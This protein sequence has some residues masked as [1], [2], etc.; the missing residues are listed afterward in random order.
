MSFYGAKGARFQGRCSACVH[1]NGHLWCL[2]NTMSNRAAI[3]DIKTKIKYIRPQLELVTDNLQ[4]EINS[5]QHFQSQINFVNSLET[6]VLRFQ[7]QVELYLEQ[8][9][10][11]ER[12]IY[13]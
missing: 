5:L 10:A 7:K 9:A 3:S 11:L 2:N 13:I 6:F 12:G 4:G 1:Q 8:R